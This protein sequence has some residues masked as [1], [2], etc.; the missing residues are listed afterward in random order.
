MRW[1][2]FLPAN[3]IAALVWALLIGVGSYFAGP[4]VVDVVQDV[5]TVGLVIALVLLVGAG[6]L[7]ALRRRH[8]RGRQ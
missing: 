2:R 8:A 7:G 3:L 1:T 5:G 4:P 6:A